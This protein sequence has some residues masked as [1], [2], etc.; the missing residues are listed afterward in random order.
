MYSK[1]DLIDLL[2]NDVEKFNVAIKDAG[3]SV[4]FSETDFSGLTLEGAIFDNIDLTSSSFADTN[5]TEVQFLGCDLTSVEF[6]RANIIE[7]QFLES[8]LNGTD[9]S[10]AVVDYG[11]FTDSDL[12]GAIFQGA[13]LSNTDFSMSENLCA[14]R[15]DEET[16]WP[17]NEFLPE[18]FDSSYSSDLSSLKDDDEYEQTEY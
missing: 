15:F 3:N 5:L 16:M 7:C 2:Q 12:A 18:N 6:T 10:Y 9:F 17:D 13:N 1:E 14:C 4:D 8:V 11:N